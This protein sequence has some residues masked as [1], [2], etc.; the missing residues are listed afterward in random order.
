MAKEARTTRSKIRVKGR[1]QEVVTVHDD[2]GAVLH[3]LIRPL[4]VEFHL[5]DFVQIM[6]GATLLAIPVGFAEEVWQLGA[7]IS[8]IQALIVMCISVLFITVF[9]YYHNYQGD[10]H[11]HRFEFLKRVVATYVVSL[12]VVSL[13]LSVIGKAPWTTD[14][15]LAFKRAVLVTLPASLSATVTDMI[16]PE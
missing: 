11:E 6:V 12:V 9:V 14:F 5:H 15:I 7:E 1:L 8:H 2:Q 13:L 3:R 16:R 10:F 4:S